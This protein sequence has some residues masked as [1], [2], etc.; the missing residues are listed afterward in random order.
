[1]RAPSPARAPQTASHHCPRYH[2]PSPSDLPSSL[3]LF[4]PRARAPATPDR[5]AAAYGSSGAV[6][7]EFFHQVASLSADRRVM[8]EDGDDDK[9]G[10]GSEKRRAEAEKLRSKRMR[11]EEQYT[12]LAEEC[13][14]LEEPQAEADML[15]EKYTPLAEAKKLEE[16]GRKRLRLEERRAEISLKME[17]LKVAGVY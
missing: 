2:H 7:P 12:P 1:M 13:T 10:A 8:S 6:I 17:A 14:P 15:E 16:L 9:M 3:A 5:H 4:Q 11:M